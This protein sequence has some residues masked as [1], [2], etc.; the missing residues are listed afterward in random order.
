MIL[1][2]D[3]FA[4][5]VYVSHEGGSVAMS[6]ENAHDSSVVNVLVTLQL[7]QI[8]DH[9]LALTDRG[10]HALESGQANEGISLRYFKIPESFTPSSDFERSGLSVGEQELMRNRLSF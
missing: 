5:L 10:R 1:L 7:L 2:S 8:R 4:F 6:D 3:E 9:R